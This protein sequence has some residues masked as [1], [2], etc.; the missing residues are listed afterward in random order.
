MRRERRRRKQQALKHLQKSAKVS[1][2]EKRQLPALETV[3]AQDR[4]RPKEM[5]SR[6]PDARIPKAKDEEKATVLSMIGIGHARRGQ[7]YDTGV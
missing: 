7:Q 1:R 2:C 6:P 5:S 4:R 3:K